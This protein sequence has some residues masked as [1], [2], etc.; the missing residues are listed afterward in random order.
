LGLR[1]PPGD[2][3]YRV[4]AVVFIPRDVSLM[5]MRADMRLRGRSFSFRAVYPNGQTEILLERPYQRAL[6]SVFERG[7]VGTL[8][9]QSGP[10][11]GSP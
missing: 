3:P 1:I 11:I 9:R 2:P 10:F 5:G 4:D 8:G 7:E 6:G